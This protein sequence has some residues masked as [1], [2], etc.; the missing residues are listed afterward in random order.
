MADLDAPTQADREVLHM[1]IVNIPGNDLEMGEVFTEFIGSG[2]H[3]LLCY[4]SFT[5]TRFGL[6]G[7]PSGSGLHRYVFLVFKQSGKLK[8]TREKTSNR[9]GA[10][11]FGFKT[12]DFVKANKL[13]GPVAGN[14]YLAQY[15]DYV[16]ILHAQLGAPP[17]TAQS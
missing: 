4:L 5:K 3:F 16:P 11:R 14:F 6:V 12:R 9:S 8:L 1:L 7:P 10:G 17:T 15:D 2:K 13:Q